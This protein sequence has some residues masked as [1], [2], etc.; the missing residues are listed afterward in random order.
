MNCPI[1]LEIIDNNF[2]ILTCDCNCSYHTQCINTWLSKNN[3]CPSCNHKFKSKPMLKLSTES[4][5]ENLKNAIY[6]DSIN[7]F[8]KFK[9][10]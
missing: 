1:C 5:N 9:Y 2:T 10:T 4:R 8:S 3:N 7:K 6:Y